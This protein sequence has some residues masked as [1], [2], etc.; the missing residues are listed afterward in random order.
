MKKAHPFPGVPFSS[1]PSSLQA[2]K[3]SATSVY[4]TPPDY[5]DPFAS[6]DAGGRGSVSLGA[7]LAC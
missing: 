7:F 6:L 4:L 5:L 2:A 1:R 3:P